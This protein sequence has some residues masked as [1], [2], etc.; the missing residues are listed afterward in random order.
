MIIGLFLLAS[1]GSKKVTPEIFLIPSGY[2]GTVKVVFNEPCG[3]KE[4]LEGNKRLYI[5]PENGVLITQFK[6]ELGIINQEYYYIDA[7]GGR[8]LIPKM[9]LQDFNEE[10]TTKINEHEPSRD[11][12]GIFQWGTTGEMQT[13][14]EEKFSFYIFQVGTYTEVRDSFTTLFQGDGIYEHKFDSI[15]NVM[16]RLCRTATVK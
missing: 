8:Q 4:S 13:Q 3:S 12:V 1:C 6:Q 5:I 16:V 14:G 2:R 7:K 11:Q 15:S 9:M 10:T